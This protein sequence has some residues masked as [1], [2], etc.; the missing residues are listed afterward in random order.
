MDRIGNRAIAPRARTF[1][2]AR[3]NRP[4]LSLSLLACALS[5]AL[6]AMAQTTEP[7]QLPAAPQASL[8]APAC[9]DCAAQEPQQLA[10]PPAM[11]DVRFTLQRVD[12][13]GA[14][15]FPESELQALVADHI[16]RSVGFADLQAL[17]QRVTQHY[18]EHGYILAQAVLPVQEVQDGAVEISVVEGRLGRVTLELD[19]AAPI[20]EGRIRTM[21]A[22]LTEGEPL[23]GPQYER[24]MLLL[25]DLPGLRVQSALEEGAA[26]GTTDLIVQVAP[27]DR[28]LGS[29]EADNYG[30][31]ETGRERIGGTVRW[32]SPMRNGDNLDFRAMVSS[33]EGT[34]F[35]RVSY[36]T[37]VGYQGLRLGVGVSRVSYTLG[38]EFEIL[39]AVGKAVILDTA[40]TYPLIRQRGHNLFLRG[41]LDRKKLTDELRAV[42]FESDKRVEGIGFGWAWERRDGFGGGGYWSSNGTLYHG[43]LKLLDAEVRAV[44]KSVFG[45]D[46]AGDFTKL[47]LQVARLQ[48]LADRLSLFAGVGAQAASKNLD[49]S[50]KLALGGYRAVRAYPTSELLVDDGVLANV[51]L[52]YALTDALTGFV[53]YDWGRGDLFHDPTPFDTDNTRELHGPGIGLNYARPGSFSVNLS[54][55]WRSSDPALTDGGD[56]KPR[57]FVQIQKTF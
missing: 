11:A 35:G 47:T 17:A 34:L 18:R 37:P 3:R 5:L 16:G 41:F 40:L 46:T 7:Q 8:Q 6:P 38:G 4:A 53:F 31:K 29:V 28:V 14:T 44:D 33:D 45:R 20:G 2:M 51:E 19:P 52:R 21:L 30:T 55:A 10:P 25:S 23:N 56:R 36:E 32:A 48:R 42:D 54:V 39:D 50:E 15:A 24:V 27:G 43:R 22:S 9:T 26:G 57:V 12:F 1:A 49:P 13:K